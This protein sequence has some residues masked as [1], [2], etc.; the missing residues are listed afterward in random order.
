[1]EESF[2]RNELARGQESCLA[3]IGKTGEPDIPMY[4]RK[5]FGAL[6]RKAGLND[7]ESRLADAVISSFPVRPRP[8]AVASA[9]ASR[10]P[11]GHRSP[12]AIQCPWQQLIVALCTF[13]LALLGA[14]I[15]PL[16]AGLF[17]VAGIPVGRLVARMVLEKRTCPDGKDSQKGEVAG[18]SVDAE[19]V[20][21]QMFTLA[22]TLDCVLAIFSQERTA[23]QGGRPELGT[24]LLLAMQKLIGA[25]VRE[26]APDVMRE[27]VKDLEE[28]LPQ[29][30]IKVLHY[31]EE[32]AGA[33]ES[34]PGTKHGVEVLPAFA[35]KGGVIL[36]GKYVL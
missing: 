11:V 33:F 22:G 5:Y 6:A 24:G 7:R 1:M 28:I 26:D 10:S 19:D 2:F 30:G 18:N 4:V 29:A 27:Y 31:S 14:L 21:N 23:V 17:A 8:A 12:S 13:M 15:K 25:S 34:A 3:D 16:F 32:N 35:D 20:C 9:T 36:P